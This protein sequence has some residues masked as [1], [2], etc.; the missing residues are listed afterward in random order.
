ML[1]FD[2]FGLRRTGRCR[3]FAF[4]Y[5]RAVREPLARSLNGQSPYAVLNKTSHLRASTQCLFLFNPPHG[6]LLTHILA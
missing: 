1:W 4:L 5:R 3:L 6:S 2:P